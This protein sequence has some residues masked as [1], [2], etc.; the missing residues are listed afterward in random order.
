MSRVIV[1]P[2]PNAV[3]DFDSLPSR[4]AGAWHCDPQRFHHQL[5]ELTLH[6]RPETILTRARA[7]LAA[8]DATQFMTD[9]FDC[10]CDIEIVSESGA[11]ARLRLFTWIAAGPEGDMEE[12]KQ[13]DTFAELT[14]Q[15]RLSGL[16]SN[17]TPSVSSLCAIEIDLETAL[18][19]NPADVRN[20]GYALLPMMLL[21]SHA[22]HAAQDILEILRP[23]PPSGWPSLARMYLGARLAIDRNGDYRDCLSRRPWRAEQDDHADQAARSY[24]AGR[25]QASLTSVLEERGLDVLA[26]GPFTWVDGV[27]ALARAAGAMAA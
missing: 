1:V 14:R 18:R 9:L 26:D 22:R 13:Q 17:R 6:P 4:L 5:A 20:L 10:A 21:Q 2:N 8:H 23:D 11:V 27:N 25:F 12:M 15:V 3:C 19:L 7:C 24:A 16:V